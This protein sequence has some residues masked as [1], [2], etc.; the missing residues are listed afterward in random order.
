MKQQEQ[1]VKFNMSLQESTKV[2][3]FQREL[4]TQ[5]LSLSKL[6]KKLMLQLKKD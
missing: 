3:M 5:G 1:Q 6:L 2:S 4:S